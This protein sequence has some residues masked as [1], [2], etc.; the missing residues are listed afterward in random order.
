MAQLVQ[1]ERGLRSPGELRRS[2]P[3]DTSLALSDG[4]QRFDTL[5]EA[6]LGDV[7]ERA[8]VIEVASEHAV[9]VVA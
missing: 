1:R 7:L 5:I 9:A 8:S 3:P 4:E 2:H 6:T